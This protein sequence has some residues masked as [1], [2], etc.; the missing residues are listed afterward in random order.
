VSVP[1]EI[2]SSNEPP[3]D[4]I[5][6]DGSHQASDV[7][8]DAI[9]AFQLLRVGGVM[10]FDDYLWC[11]RPTGEEDTLNMPKAA[12]DSFISLFQRK[13]KV[14]S[15]LPIDQLYIEKN[16][17]V[18]LCSNLVDEHMKPAIFRSCRQST[19]RHSTMASRQM[20]DKATRAS[21]SLPP[22][23]SKIVGVSA[24]SVDGM[25]TERSRSPRRGCA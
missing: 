14:I 4:L 5:Y 19:W 12:I 3:F 21:S 6:V 20:R 1:A 2:L 11:M 16:I 13:L 22:G 9:I 25:H 17:F 23:R 18:R 8:T 10:I 24:R 15:G 7:L